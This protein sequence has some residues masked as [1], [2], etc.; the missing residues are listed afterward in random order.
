ML[1]NIVALILMV[2]MTAC[3]QQD[4]TDA[5]TVAARSWCASARNCTVHEPN[6]N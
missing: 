5:G 3:T 2:E 6:S 4:L 1:K